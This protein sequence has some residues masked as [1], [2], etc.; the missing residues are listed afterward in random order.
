MHASYCFCVCR[1]MLLLMSKC[2]PAL[3]LQWALEK[4]KFDKIKSV[5][6]NN[7]FEVSIWQVATFDAYAPLELSNLP[8]AF[9]TPRTYANHHKNLIVKF[10]AAPGSLLKRKKLQ[11]EVLSGKCLRKKQ[12]VLFSPSPCLCLINCWTLF[13]Q[14]AKTK[15]TLTN[16][17]WG[18]YCDLRI[19]F[20]PT[21]IYGPSAF[22]L[23]P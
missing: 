1:L 21:L 23:W 17:F 18:P 16:Q 5:F 12:F 22:N 8:R 11:R 7:W 13:Q 9:I 20:F 2:E 3:S 6:Y 4:L 19:A 10:R 14:I 15:K